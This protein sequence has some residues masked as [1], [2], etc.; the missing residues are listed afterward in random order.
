MRQ[1]ATFP[2]GEISF[3]KRKLISWAGNFSCAVVID[4]CQYPHALSEPDFL[5][6]ADTLGAVSFE[7]GNIFRSIAAFHD[8]HKDWLFGYLTYD[9]KNETEPKVLF[10]NPTHFDGIQF[11]A[12][13]FFRPKHIVRLT[14]DRVTIES[15]DNPESVYASI[16]ATD[17]KTEVNPKQATLKLRMKPEEYFSAVLKLQQ[18]ILNGDVY[19]VNFCQEFFAEEYVADPVNLYNKLT[20]INP[21]PYSTFFRHEERYLIASSPER[22]MK[23]SG[24]TICSQPMKGTSARVHAG[25]DPEAVEQ[26]RNDPKERSENVMI[27]DL[28]RNDLARSALPGTVKVDELFGIYSFSTVHQMVSSISAE[29]NPQLHFIDAIRHAFP[30]GSMTGAPKIRA[31]QLIGDYER[32]K[33]GLYSGTVGHISPQ[34]DFDFF[35]VIRSLLYNSANRYLSFQT[36]SAI[37]YDSVPEKE[38]EESMLKAKALIAALR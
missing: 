37:T 3:L 5:V 15:A 11:P 6:A 9:V 23:K 35:V 17:F 27:V 18:H 31:M 20:S 16:L 19:E 36:G 7:P 14:H 1:S 30:M 32:T 13:H 34:G 33:R 29:L 10:D 22:F 4:H 28:V 38:Y 12:A 25:K 24:N 21:A 8:L 26:L 2:A